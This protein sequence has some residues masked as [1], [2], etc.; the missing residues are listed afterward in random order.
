MD[1]F[2]ED[3]KKGLSAPFK[4]LSSKY[5]YDQAGD[6]L[7]Q[8]L[9][10]SPEYYLS[11]SELSILQ[12][13]SDKLAQMVAE[14]F[15]ELDLVELGAGD[16]SKSVYLIR[17]LLAT[18]IDFTY[19]PIDISE[20]VINLLNKKFSESLPNLN[21]HG[22]NGDYLKM[23]TQQRNLSTKQLLILF[24]GSNIG[25]MNHREAL[26]FCV[27]VGSFMKKDDFFLVGIDLKKDPSVILRAYDD[28]AGLTKAFNL[29]FLTRIN[30][31]LGGNFDIDKFIHL[32]RYNPA[33]GECRSFLISIADQTVTI[34]MADKQF[35]VHFHEHE[36]IHMEIS[37]KYD[38]SEIES[39]AHEAGFKITNHF[40]DDKKWFVNS[41]WQKL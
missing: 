21:V 39:L 29:N 30:R 1:E 12:K 26:S 32:P 34:G 5:F 11:R 8:K 10:H 38:L 7:F 19:Y 15:S 25:N 20:N 22:L 2:Y 23:L 3:V 6:M 24:L 27:S 40:F 35:T 33:N 16:A 14:R 4:S 17:A 37:K 18:G 36:S 9:M 31:E 41:L 13:Q 28:R